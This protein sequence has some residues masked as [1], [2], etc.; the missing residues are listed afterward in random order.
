MHFIPGLSLRCDEEAEIVGI[1][2]YD[3][4]EFAYDYVGVEQDL[5]VK[6]L[7]GGLERE[8]IDATSDGREPRHADAD[9]SA[10]VSEIVEKRAA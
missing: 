8:R 9:S 2:D 4:G 7:E 10:A 3:M 6:D 1:D 5:G